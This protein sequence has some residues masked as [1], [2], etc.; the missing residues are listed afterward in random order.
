MVKR[1]FI[2]INVLCMEEIVEKEEVDLL[3]QH[4]VLAL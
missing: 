3:G 1:R 2:G 4:F